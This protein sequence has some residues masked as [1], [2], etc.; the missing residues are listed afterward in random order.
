MC[1]GGGSKTEVKSLVCSF[2]DITAQKYA[3]DAYKAIVDNSIQGLIVFQDEKIIFANNAVENILG[4][5]PEQ[6]RNFTYKDLAELANES[7]SEVLE[8]IFRIERY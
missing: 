4:Y 3:E 5:S 6:F 2:K 7:D 8:N 1:D